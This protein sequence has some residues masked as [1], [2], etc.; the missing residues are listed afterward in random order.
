MILGR[1]ESRR[2]A[3]WIART[4]AGIM[5]REHT[6]LADDKD[7]AA[8]DAARRHTFWSQEPMVDPCEATVIGVGTADAWRVTSVYELP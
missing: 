1:L 5:P 2:G 3:R 8:L 6:H 7:T 4:E